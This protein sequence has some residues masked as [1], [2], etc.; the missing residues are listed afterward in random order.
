[1]SIEQIQNGESGASVR[2]K[3]NAAIGEINGL[4]TAAGAAAA[5]FATAAQGALAGTALQPGAQ[6]PW[7]NILDAPS[8]TDGREVE[9]Q[10]TAT[11]IEWRYVGEAAWSVLV[12]LSEIAGPA[13]ADGVAGQDGAPG[14]QGPQGDTGPQGP[15]GATGATGPAGPQGEEGPQ[16]PAGPTG[17]QGPAGATGPQGPEGP[18]GATTIGGIDGLQAALD[19]RVLVVDADGNA[20]TAR[21]S[22]AAVVMW[23]NSPSE[24]AN[25]APGDLWFEAE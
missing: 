6:I 3:L 24:P 17:P 2:G 18:S 4:G 12:P 20:S 7:S 15:A 25:A 21:P 9:L 5:D 16:G 10:A 8:V 11:D 23:I 13:G 1:M 19:A 14:P 22:G